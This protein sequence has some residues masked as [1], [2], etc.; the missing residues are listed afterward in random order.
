[1]FFATTSPLYQNSGRFRFLNAMAT[2]VVDWIVH[3]WYME[4]ESRCFGKMV[5]VGVHCI[6]ER[7]GVNWVVG[8]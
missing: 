4:V 6:S 2:V 8:T 1:M 5:Q 7:E 3:T